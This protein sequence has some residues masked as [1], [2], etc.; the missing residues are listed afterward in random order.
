MYNISKPGYDLHF[1]RQLHVQSC[2]HVHSEMDYNNGVHETCWMGARM[3]DTHVTLLAQSS[4]SSVR[5]IELCL[6]NRELNK[7]CEEEL[8][9]SAMCK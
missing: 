1:R 8:E 5:F 6:Q 7:A 9:S 4:R 3:S 2:N